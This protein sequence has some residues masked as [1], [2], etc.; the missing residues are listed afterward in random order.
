MNTNPYS[1]ISNYFYFLLFALVMT[2]EILEVSG[3]WSCTPL[4]STLQMITLY[5]V[6][7]ISTSWKSKAFMYIFAAL[8]IILAGV[9]MKKYRISGA[10]YTLCLGAIGMV[11]STIFKLILENSKPL[12]IFTLMRITWA[13]LLIPVIILK[14]LEWIYAD[15]LIKIQSI[16]LIVLLA[17]FVVR[18]FMS[19]KTTA[20][21]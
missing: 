2:V 4:V 5:Y 12:N 17:V 16:L 3:L 15:K 14:A 18:E 11:S 21:E 6:Y 10:N 9:L 20:W 19:K 7:E 1:K 8:T 13:V